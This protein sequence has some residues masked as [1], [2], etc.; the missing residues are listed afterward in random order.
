MHWEMLE[1]GELTRAEV[2]V[3]RFGQL[4]SELGVDVDAQAVAK[5]CGGLGMNKF[6]LQAPVCLVISE[7]PYVKSAAMGALVKGTTP[8][9]CGV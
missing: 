4:F 3:N 2:L 7:M 5:A 8:G 9:P 6:A 1:R